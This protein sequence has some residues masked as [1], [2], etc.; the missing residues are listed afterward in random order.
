M[1]PAPTKPR[2][3]LTSHQLRSPPQKDQAVMESIVRRIRE[4][5]NTVSSTASSERATANRSDPQTPFIAGPH[6][7][8]MASKLEA[9]RQG[10]IRRLAIVVPPRHLKSHG[11]SIAFVAWCLGHNPALH[12]ICASYGQDLADKL[13]RDCRTV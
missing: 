10:K 6:I 8:L 1:R 4:A 2:L 3:P 7:E 5:A 12:L 9:C 13:A 11:A